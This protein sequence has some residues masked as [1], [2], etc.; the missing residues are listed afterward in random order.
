MLI[1]NLNIK[2]VPFKVIRD[3]SHAKSERLM[4]T[5]RLYRI[6]TWF[7]HRRYVSVIESA[8]LSLEKKNC[9][10]KSFL[11]NLLLKH[12]AIPLAILST[13]NPIQLKAI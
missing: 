9:S 13:K 8:T 11:T 10:S 2:P 3:L 12:Y 5:L 1:I 7:Y 6:F 4:N